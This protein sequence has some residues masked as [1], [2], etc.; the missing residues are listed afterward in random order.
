M[1]SVILVANPSEI[2]AGTRGSSLGFEAL[3]IAGW[4]KGSDLLK[5][6]PLKRIADNNEA[7]YE[8]DLNPFAHRIAAITRSFE[9]TAMVLDPVYSNGDFPVLIGGDHSVAAG[10]LSAVKK[11]FP[12]K[13]LGV[14]WIDAH[15]DMHT[16][17]TTPS[18]NFHGMPLAIALG[19]DNLECRKN[20]PVPQTVKEWNAVKELWGICP[21][22][23]PE[24]VVFFGVRST[25]AE[26]DAIMRRFSMPNVTVDDFRA[27][28]IDWAIEET[29]KRL[30]SCDIVYISFDV[31]SMDPK[32]SSLGTGT[33][34]EHGFTPEECKSIIAQ[35]FEKLNV[36]CF[37]MV[38]INPTLD[39]KGNAMAETAHD[40]LEDVVGLVENKLHRRSS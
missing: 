37:E 26:E 1:P 36:V 2:G 33:P 34:V 13:R 6:Y 8:P 38:E 16:P 19:L 32:F 4:K 29:A 5:R 3:R 31:D 14:V 7:L 40:I 18:G 27:K 22:V 11:S 9:D 24:D 15:A 30:S 25:E 39:E 28:G 17:Y 12:N 35:L 21:K 10:T 23:N 20:D